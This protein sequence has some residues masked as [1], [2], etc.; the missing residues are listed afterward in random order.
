MLKP[1]LD[2]DGPS[3]PDSKEIPI[4]VPGIVGIKLWIFFKNTWSQR[5]TMKNKPW[6]RLNLDISKIVSSSRMMDI[7]EE[8]REMSKEHP[9]LPAWVYRLSW[10]NFDSGFLQYL[11]QI[12]LIPNF[13]HI[14]YRRPGVHHGAAGLPHIDTYWEHDIMDL[15]HYAINYVVGDDDS[16]MIWYETPDSLP[17]ALVLSDR[18]SYILFDQ[19]LPEDTITDRCYVGSTT[20]LIRTDIPHK[21]ITGSNERFCLSLRLTD[22]KNSW[23]EAVE[24]FKPWISMT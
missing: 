19:G 9:E 6:Y 2:P 11:H 14:I 3:V 1:M 15:N 23:Q 12:D 18:Q 17:E 21:V 5:H 13:C 7:F 20:T 24:F 22:R 16:E 8:L 4:T 10:R